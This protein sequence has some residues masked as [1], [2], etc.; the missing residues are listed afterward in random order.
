MRHETF[1]FPDPFPAGPKPHKASARELIERVGAWH[2]ISRDD[3]V[4]YTRRRTVMA[5]RYDAIAAV[6]IAYPN[7]TTSALGRIFRRDHSTIYY[8]LRK[9]GLK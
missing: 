6:K 5:A 1:T 8:A 9:R 3:I 7:L 2:G 4:R